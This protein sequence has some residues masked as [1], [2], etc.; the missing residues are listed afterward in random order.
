MAIRCVHLL[1]ETRIS[2]DEGRPDVE[3]CLSKPATAIRELEGSWGRPG[4]ILGKSFGLLFYRATRR[5]LPSDVAEWLPFQILLDLAAMCVLYDLLRRYLPR[6]S[7]QRSFFAL[8]GCAMWAASSG[9]VHWSHRF[10]G[11]A[12]CLPAMVCFYWVLLRAHGDDRN[13]S[14]TWVGLLA[15][16]CF[17]VYPGCYTIVGI[18]LLI[19]AVDMERGRLK[20]TAQ[21]LLLSGLVGGAFL[22]GYDLILYVLATVLHEPVRSYFATLRQLSQSIKQGTFAEV[23]VYPFRFWWQFPDVAAL[24]ALPGVLAGLVF[25]RGLG[26]RFCLIPIAVYAFWVANGYVLHREVMYDRIVVLLSPALFIGATFA[27]AQLFPQVRRAILFGFAAAV[28][29]GGMFVMARFPIVRVRTQDVVR[30]LADTTGDPQDQIVIVSDV[31]D[32]GT[33]V[34]KFLAYAR[35]QCREKQADGKIPFVAF[36][37]RSDW[38]E[39]TPRLRLEEKPVLRYPAMG[40]D[41]GVDY[42]S[43]RDPPPHLVP[44]FDDIKVY[45]ARALDSAT[46]DDNL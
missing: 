20:R 14:W 30:H 16:A 1:D 32:Y 26:R 19:V 25:A 17:W 37:L 2:W 24:V 29:A 33:E 10:M 40:R 23:P 27:A 28:I 6:E 7:P 44:R 8:A 9:I 42:L 43:R 5:V 4:L 11:P 21:R 15:A 46:I 38:Y 3:S 35:Q 31:N 36:N 12:Y 41:G 22:V 34:A 45:D 39:T 18:S 13:W